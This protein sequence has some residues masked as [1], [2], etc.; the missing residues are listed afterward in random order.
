[1]IGLK[2]EHPG[3]I[4]REEY[5]EPLGITQTQLARETGI[6]YLRVNELVNG[7]RGITPDTAM[8]LAKY[9]GTSAEYWMNWQSAF[10]LQKAET[11]HHKEYERIPAFTPQLITR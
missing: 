5:L 7:K 6:S 2:V 8:R 3:I 11:E 1:M 10:D 9:L 4:L